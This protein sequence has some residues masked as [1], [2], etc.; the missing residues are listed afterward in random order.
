MPKAAKKLWAQCV[1]EALAQIV[2][3]NDVMAWAHFFMLPKAVLRSSF[4]GGKKQK[5]SGDVETKLLCAR[6][7]EG[8]RQVLWNQGRVPRRA[9]KKKSESDLTPEAME[10]VADLVAQGQLQKACSLLAQNL[11]RTLRENW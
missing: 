6:W 11:Q 10:R 7:L 1:T 3:F 8:Q 9:T 4:R 5:K 2:E